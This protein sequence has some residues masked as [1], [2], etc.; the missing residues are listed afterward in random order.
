MAVALGY[1]GVYAIQLALY[2]LMY[3][4][5]FYASG[6]RLTFL[7]LTPCRY[8]PALIITDV[9]CRIVDLQD[10]DNFHKTGFAFCVTLLFAMLAATPIVWWCR[11]RLALF[12]PKKLVNFRTLL[13]CVTL[14]SLLWSLLGYLSGRLAVVQL[15]TI[16]RYWLLNVYV[17]LYMQML[18]VIPWAL[19]VRAELQSAIPFRSR[20]REFSKQFFAADTLLLLLSGALFLI[21]LIHNNQG[22][23]Q[24]V[25]LMA[26]FLPI[27]W[28]LFK[29]GWRAAAFG[30]TPAIVYIGSLV[31]VGYE[32]HSFEARTFLALSIT[33]ILALGVRI[34]VQRQRDELEGFENEEAIRMARQSI[35]LGEMRMR[36]T[37]RALELAGHALHLT[38]HQLL[39]RFNNVMS[40]D[41]A[42]RYYRQAAVTQK[43]VSRLAD[44]MYPSAWRERGLAAALRETIADALREAGL[45]YQCRIDGCVLDDIT[46]AMHAAVYRL[47]CETVAYIN[48]QV[49]CSGIQLKL[50]SG[51]TNNAYWVALRVAGVLEIATVNDP[52]YNLNERDHLAAKLGAHGLGFVALRN[53]ARLFD[54]DVR[55]RSTPKGLTLIYLLIDVTDRSSRSLSLSSVTQ[56]WVT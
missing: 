19:M 23:S 42:Q 27:A 47:A 2:P 54:G 51:V 33:C 48:A 9:G 7:L 35:Q 20:L 28:L 45:A 37:A 31:Q 21:W 50:R 1:A 30:S 12:P 49:M 17:S 18:A 44:S 29:P 6:F 4:H 32:K 38:Q 46:P 15:P 14:V 25:S 3:G 22:D 8:W 16:N 24:H 43:Q 53:H 34:A 5:S 10:G 55:E 41:E 52:I 11:E 40:P 13:I 36:K 26:V 39:E 56:P